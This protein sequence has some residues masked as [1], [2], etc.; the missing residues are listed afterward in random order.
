MIFS[1][2]HSISY[3]YTAPVSLDSHCIRLLPRKGAGQRIRQFELDIFPR[4]EGT[5]M[6]L[7]AEN[8]EIVS[9]WFSR[10][11][12][13]FELQS[14][15]LVETSLENPF[16]FLLAP[17]EL[18]L[19]M[20]ESAKVLFHATLATTPSQLI[21][22]LVEQIR[23]KA[24]TPQTFALHV[25]QWI[26]K[27]ITISARAQG[28]AKPAEETLS[29]KVGACRDVSCLMMMMCRR[30]GIPARFVSGYCFHGES[31]IGHE[32]HSWVEAWLP[33]GGWRGFD[34]SLGLATSTNHV[35]LCASAE[36]ANTLPVQGA[37]FGRAQS[38]MKYSV[39]LKLIPETETGAIFEPSAAVRLKA[40]GR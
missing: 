30:V 37:F 36:P 15:F 34:P 35:A 26:A 12:R 14:R 9:V 8:N 40:A 7:D 33:N 29:C 16:S 31:H 19:E 2:E 10:P 28:A 22:T 27:N 18:P 4:P 11:T 23:V 39:D 3:S 13:Y 17:G 20:S 1:G 5:E 24:N 21:D 32:L 6:I 25:C 38:N